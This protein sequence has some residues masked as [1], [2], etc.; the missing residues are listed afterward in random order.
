MG[1]MHLPQRRVI[2][3]KEFDMALIVILIC[4]GIQRYLDFSSANF[5]IDWVGTYIDMMREKVSQINASNGLLGNAILILPIL[6]AVAILFGLVF[7]LLT[8][9]GYMLL[10]VIALWYCIDAR[11]PHKL[12]AQTTDGTPV[13]MT[14][15][16][17]V[18]ALI[19]W[20]VI[21]GPIGLA[22]YFTVTEI[23]RSLE[24]NSNDKESELLKSAMFIQ[25][26]LDWVPVRLLGFTFALVSHFNAV[27][28]V[29]IQHLKTGLNQ[30]PPLLISITN[31]ALN[32]KEGR[33]DTNQAI[34]LIDRA[35]LAWLVVIALVSIAFWIG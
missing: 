19:F 29:W 34:E 8:V 16:Q 6:L 4:L 13:I 2:N 35:L 26:I 22:L 11:D 23:V 15:Y 7:H 28:P 20:Y 27:F 32:S 9:V 17:C 25:Q 1:I 33:L 24:T 21:L 10:S 30:E 31:A 12:Y 5:Q 14:T 3:L 18:F